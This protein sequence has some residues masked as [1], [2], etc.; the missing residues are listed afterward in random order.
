M[1]L[2]DGSR[3]GYR[4]PVVCPGLSLDWDAIEGARDSLGKFGVTSNYAFELAPYTGSWCRTCAAARR[5]LPSHPC[6]S[7]VPAHRRRP[8]TCPAIT[9]ASTAY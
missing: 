6:R 2:E 8:C 7:S 1:V 4:A 9:G 3:I 5:C